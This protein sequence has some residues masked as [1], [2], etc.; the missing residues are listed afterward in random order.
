MNLSLEAAVIEDNLYYNLV[1][2]TNKKESDLKGIGLYKLKIEDKIS[3]YFTLKL[4]C[5]TYGN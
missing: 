4:D 1:S 3:V 5:L 2:E